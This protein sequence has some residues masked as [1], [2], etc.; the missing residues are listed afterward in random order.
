MAVQGYGERVIT[1]LPPAPPA[2]EQPAPY[3]LS[4]GTVA[5]TAAPGTRRVVV[6]AGGRVLADVPLAG[7]R[8]KLRVDLPLHETTVQVVTVDG[9]G[10]RASASTAHVLGAPRAAAPR[11][12]AARL[13]Q[14]LARDVRRAA[15]A[16]GPTSGIYVESLTSGA[17]AAWNARATFPGASTLKLAIAVTALAHLE[18]AP[19]HGS[20]LDRL[21]RQMLV[22]SDNAA[23]N[24]VERAYGGST[25]G[26]SALVNALMRS[27]GL[28]DTEM[29]GGYETDG[30][31][32]GAVRLPAAAI[33]LLVESQPAWGYGKRTTA[34]DLSALLRGVW[35][36]SAGLGPLR[37][38]QPGFTPADA[39]YLL[40]VLA[41]VG[42][43]GKLDRAVGAAA[44]VRVLHKAGWIGTA[45]HD[46]GIVF[47]PGGAF[48]A[49][50]MTYRPGGAGIAS[51][52]LAG[53]VARMALDRFRG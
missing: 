31:G 30:Y 46:N 14:F 47:W 13:D 37:S 4:F 35:L 52:I 38:A 36:A 20:Y 39:R 27:L 23:A 53:R 15:A 48:V 11:W 32:A 2:I 51:D 49:T 43:H 41:R 50:V 6:R 26:G 21:L 8:F 3:E 34:R 1:A 5:G 29:Y 40:Y 28:V 22:H 25:S 7:R 42:D 16:F 33:P 12:R 44:G 18:G 24:A 9:K 10:R 17:G 45:R 19:G